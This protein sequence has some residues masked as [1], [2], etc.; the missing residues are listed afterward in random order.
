[1]VTFVVLTSILLAISLLI[2]WIS[3]SYNQFQVLIIRINEAEANI[4]AV[5]RFT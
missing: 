3:T 2:I 5:L 1:M 4:D